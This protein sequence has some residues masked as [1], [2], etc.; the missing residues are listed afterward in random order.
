MRFKGLDLN[1]L[2]AFDTLLEVRSVT[3]AA[4]RLHLSQAAMSAALGRL[5][6]FFSDEILVVQGKRMYPTVFAQNLIPQVQQ[7]LQ[8][9]DGMLVT[10]TR[11]N[12]QVSQ[13]VFRVVASDYVTSVVLVPLIT[14]LARTAPGIRIELLLPSDTVLTQIEHGDID[15]LITP[16]DYVSP[17]LPTELLYEESHVMAGWRNNPAFSAEMTEEQF[18]AAGHVTVSIG[19]QGTIS[20]GDRMLESMGK[21]RR[22]EVTAPSFT[23]IPWLLVDTSRLAIMP[24]RLAK[25]MSERFDIAS[26][27]L[28]FAI[29]AMREMVQHHFTRNADAGLN[30]FRRELHATAAGSNP[31]N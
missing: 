12:P 4:E 6:D 25:S 5:R 23:L 16:E 19:N 17:T 1:L 3:R 24:E 8:Q 28:P 27:A 20:F 14:Q 22:I 10:S 9:I 2:V 29:P 21:K 18:F 31:K 13:R 15:L 26:Y 7:C 30:W 11:F